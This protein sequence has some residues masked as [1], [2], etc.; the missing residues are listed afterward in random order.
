MKRFVFA[1]LVFSLCTA[2][3]MPTRAASP[4][5]VASRASFDFNC[6]EASVRVRALSDRTFGATGCGK[7]AT[8]VSQCEA[9]NH[10]AAVLNSPVETSG[11]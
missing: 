10:C 9:G 5:D 7:R 4:S 3:V 8:Y 2:C 6:P 11:Q 1:A